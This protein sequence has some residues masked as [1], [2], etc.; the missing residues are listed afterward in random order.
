M[1]RPF[2]STSSVHLSARWFYHIMSSGYSF[3]HFKLKW[4]R[5]HPK[6]R[7]SLNTN[8]RRHQPYL[9]DWC[10]CIHHHSVFLYTVVH[11]AAHWL[12]LASSCF[13]LQSMMGAA[14]PPRLVPADWS[15]AEGE[16]REERR[17][18]EGGREK[19]LLAVHDGYHGDQSPACVCEYVRAYILSK[20]T[21]SYHSKDVS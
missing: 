7:S 21:S 3:F 5:T 20:M 16:G 14:A 18:R 12:P 19:G 8:R 2:K 17:W 11:Y 13:I 1:Y 9:P 15:R 4:G 6:R 10:H